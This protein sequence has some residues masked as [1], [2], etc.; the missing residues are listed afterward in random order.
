MCKE[1]NNIENN[2]INEKIEHE[3]YVVEQTVEIFTILSKTITIV[4]QLQ[5]VLNETLHVN[6]ISHTTLS[7]FIFVSWSKSPKK[8]LFRKKLY[9][10]GSSKT[11]CPT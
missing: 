10:V 9:R 8:K 11:G 3:I 7:I 5:V 6:V 4:R 2:E 1:G